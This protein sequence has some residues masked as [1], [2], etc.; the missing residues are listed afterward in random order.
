MAGQE[1]EDLCEHLEMLMC[2]ATL[3]QSREIL[4]PTKLKVSLNINVAQRPK[5]PLDQRGCVYAMDFHPGVAAL[6]SEFIP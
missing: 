5:P 2:C 4:V 1:A 3:H 6:R